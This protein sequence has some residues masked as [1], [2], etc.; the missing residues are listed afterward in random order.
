MAHATPMPGD[1]APTLKANA[2]G[3]QAIDLAADQPEN[4][5]LIFFYRGV[6]CPICKAQLEELN[7]KLDGFAEIGV[8]VHVVSMDDEVRARKQKQDWA[9]GNLA[10]GYGLSEEAARAWGLFISE[11]A[12]EGEPARFS[13]PGVAVVRPDGTI[14]AL[15]LQNVPFARPTIDGIRQGLTFI[16]QKNYPIRGTVAA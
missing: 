5:S 12:K 9:I 13:E 11:G 6:H 14:Y 2:L 15:M 8:D 3:G 4:F 1:K 7:G 10:V 16:I